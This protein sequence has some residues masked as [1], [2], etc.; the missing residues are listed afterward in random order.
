M[1]NITEYSTLYHYGC[2]FAAGFDSDGDGKHNFHNSYPNHLS[3]ILGNGIVNHARSGSS[4]DVSFMQ[5]F[6]DLYNNIIKEDSAIIFNLTQIHRTQYMDNERAM[7][8]HNYRGPWRANFSLRDIIQLNEHYYNFQMVQNPTAEC[9]DTGYRDG[10]MAQDEIAHYFNLVRN[11]YAAKAICAQYGVPIIVVDLHAN[12]RTLET[13]KNHPLDIDNS[14]IEETGIVRKLHGDHTDSRSKSGH[15]Y[16]SGY[17]QIA[18]YMVKKLSSLTRM[19]N[20]SII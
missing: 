20:D 11:V 4:N 15:L 19:I 5:L 16:S 13:F 9:I 1:K 8:L 2:S 12:L 6:S 10:Y 18:E 3:R 17:L 7:K 14:I